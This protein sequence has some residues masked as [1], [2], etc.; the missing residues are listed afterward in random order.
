MTD[1]DPARALQAE[2]PLRLIAAAH[3]AGWRHHCP[4]DGGRPRCFG[5]RSEVPEGWPPSAAQE[6]LDREDD[7]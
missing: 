4:P 5:P 3:R 6:E 7:R 1:D 2:C